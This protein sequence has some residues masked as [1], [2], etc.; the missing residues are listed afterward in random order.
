MLQLGSNLFLLNQ[1][2]SSASLLQMAGGGVD[3]SF[4]GNVWPQ[5]DSLDHVRWGMG[6]NQPSLMRK[7]IHHNSIIRPLLE[8]LRDMIFGFAGFLTGLLISY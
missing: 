5:F 2:T 3:T 6:D 1:G 8:S 7:V 4:G